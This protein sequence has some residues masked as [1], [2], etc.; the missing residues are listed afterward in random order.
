[1]NKTLGQLP[2]NSGSKVDPDPFLE[3]GLNML[4]NAYAMAQFYDRDAPAEMAS[5]GMKGFQ[6]YMV[7]PDRRDKILERLEK[8]PPFVVFDFLIFLAILSSDLAGVLPLVD[9]IFGKYTF[10]GCSKFLFSFTFDLLVMI[11]L[12]AVS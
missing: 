11:K 3:A 9:Q 6:E 8:L 1:M 12:Q 5:E 10:P 4:N 7:N 2:V